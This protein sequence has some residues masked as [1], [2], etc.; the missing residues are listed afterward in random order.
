MTLFRLRTY[1]AFPLGLATLVS[2]ATFNFPGDLWIG[3]AMV[4]GLVAIGLVVDALFDSVRREHTHGTP[5][6]KLREPDR[7]VLLLF[8]LVLL[9]FCVADLKVNGLK[10]L[11]PESYADLSS[12]GT[13]VRHVS[14]MSWVF[15]VL[16]F[17]IR[18]RFFSMF[19]LSCGFLFPVLFV[20]R[21]RLL[22]AL[23]CYGFLKLY[24]STPVERRRIMMM[25]GCIVVT[26]VAL[27]LAVGVYRSGDAF[28]VES[29]GA[30]IIEGY[31][32]L[33]P[34]FSSLPPTLQQLLLYIGSPIFN[35]VGLLFSGT[36]EPSVLIAQTLPFLKSTADTFELGFAVP[37]FNVGTEFLPF[38]L[39]GGYEAVIVGY[40]LQVIGCAAALLLYAR[41]GSIFFLLLLLRFLYCAVMMGFAPQFFTYTNY[42]FVVICIALFLVSNLLRTLRQSVT[43]RRDASVRGWRQVTALEARENK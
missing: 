1:V 37:R 27:F 29:S 38:V 15:V 4:F 36:R 32:P 17:F 14:N 43:D 2:L 24:R 3:L 22:Q 6:L 8:C 28:V 23:F 5:R 10:I 33:R 26:I 39:F 12:T 21:N 25:L 18:T 35:F 40:V 41:T 7:N 16:A 9:V 30:T 20:D 11:A 19:W 42:G 34:Y 13:H 31:F